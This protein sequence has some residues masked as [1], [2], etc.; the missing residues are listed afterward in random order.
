MRERS[1]ALLILCHNPVLLI[2]GGKSNEAKPKYISDLRGL[3]AAFFGKWVFTL[4]NL[5]PLFLRGAESSHQICWKLLQVRLEAAHSL[6]LLMFHD[7]NC[8]SMLF[9][10]DFFFL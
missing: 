4:S 7:E 2:L 10:I 1:P 3:T 5:T 9:L 6:E 8:G